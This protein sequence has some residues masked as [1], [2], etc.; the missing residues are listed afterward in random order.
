MSQLN[1][2]HRPSKDFIIAITAS[3]RHL[4]VARNSGM[5]FK[6]SLA[7]LSLEGRYDIRARAQSIHLNCNA[8]RLTIIDQMS[9]LTVYEFNESVVTQQNVRYAQHRVTQFRYRVESI[10]MW[11]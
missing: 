1:R 7:T 2:V 8:S 6:L 3:D 5:L 4:Y 11:R 9:M 10:W